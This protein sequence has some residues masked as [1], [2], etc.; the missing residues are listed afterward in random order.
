M[1]PFQG[2]NFKIKSKLTP[3]MHVVSFY[4]AYTVLRFYL[5][6][7]VPCTLTIG[8]TAEINASTVYVTVIIL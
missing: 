6:I 5:L 8:P 2:Q 7:V 4:M 1:G 3:H